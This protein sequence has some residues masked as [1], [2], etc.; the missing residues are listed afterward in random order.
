MINNSLQSLD[1]RWQTLFRSGRHGATVKYVLRE[2]SYTSSQSFLPGRHCS[3]MASYPEDAESSGDSQR[4]T[5][6][7]LWF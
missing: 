7:Q 5:D 2:P 3:A 4:V 6:D 1:S